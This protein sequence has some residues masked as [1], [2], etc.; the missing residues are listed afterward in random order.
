MLNKFKKQLNDIWHTLRKWSLQL[1][2][3]DF[4][5]AYFSDT[6]IYR[7]LLRNYLIESFIYSKQ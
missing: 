4:S 1:K 2:V 6:H 7:Y 5:L 3:K